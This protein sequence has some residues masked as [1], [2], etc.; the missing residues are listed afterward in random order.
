MFSLASNADVPLPTVSSASHWDAFSMRFLLAYCLALHHTGETAGAPC[1]MLCPL[2]FC[3][4]ISEQ[5]GEKMTLSLKTFFLLKNNITFFLQTR[6][7]WKEK[8]QLQALPNIIFPFLSPCCC[9]A[10][11]HHCSWFTHLNFLIGWAKCKHHLLLE[12]ILVQHAQKNGAREIR[13]VCVAPG[14]KDETDVLRVSVVC[15]DWLME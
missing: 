8:G 12:V 4:V 9:H 5:E 2:F 1:T 11:I 3:T 13:R 15:T 14:L 10:L 6:S 7:T